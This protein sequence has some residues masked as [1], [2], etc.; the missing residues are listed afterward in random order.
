LIG[1]CGHGLRKAQ[2]GEECVRDSM[3]NLTRVALT[4]DLGLSTPLPRLQADFGQDGVLV[5]DSPM[6]SD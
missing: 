1:K 4:T 6:G 3:G 2:T 5:D